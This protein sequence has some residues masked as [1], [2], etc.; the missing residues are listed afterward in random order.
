[1]MSELEPTIII[2]DGDAEV[3]TSLRRLLESVRLRVE[4]FAT[5]PAFLDRYN[6]RT[7][8]CLIL[9]V[10]LRDLSGVE[11]HRR[12]RRDGSRTPVIFLTEYADVTTA[13]DAIRQGAF[14]FLQKPVN[15]QYFLDQVHAAVAK[16][17]QDRTEDAK[18]RAACAR[19][20]RLSP[21]EWDILAEI[22]AGRTNKEAA[23]RFGVTVKTIEFHRANVMK[24]A[25]VDSLAELVCLLL[26]SGWKP[27]NNRG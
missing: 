13:V 10:R 25:G 6:P 3:R 16:D 17:L 24:K 12:L 7:P 22:L 18:R 20:E 23:R 4:A 5:A 14:H 27:A 26:R 19:F 15:E 11:L 2:V 8:G 21:R 9:E 1:M